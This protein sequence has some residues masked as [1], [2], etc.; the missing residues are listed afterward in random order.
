MKSQSFL[1]RAAGIA[2]IAGL[3]AGC[4]TSQL[5]TL[6]GTTGKA[7]PAGLAIASSGAVRAGGAMRPDRGKSWM[8]PSKASCT[9]NGKLPPC[10]LLYVSNYYDDDVLVF[11]NDKL[12]GTL[13]GFD[14]PDGL[15]HDASGNV[16]IVNNLGQ[17]IVEYAHGGTTQIK[18]LSDPGEFPLGCAVNP[19]TGAVV[20][21]NIFTSGSGQGS[22]AVYHKAAGPP[23]ILTDPDIYYVYFCGFDNEGN[24]YIDGFDTS[25]HFEFAQLPRNGHKF[26]NIALNG[27]IYWPGAI[28]WDGKYV[29]VGDQMYQDQVQ[30]AAYQTTGV[31]G[32]IAG[33]TVFSGAQD[34]VGFDIKDTSIIGP[35]A[36]L[37]IVGL[38]PYPAGGSATAK[39]GH[40][41]H[42]YGATISTQHAPAGAAAP[43][44][45]APEPFAS[46]LFRAPHGTK[47]RGW[48][49]PSVRFRRTVYVADDQEVLIFPQGPRNP[50]PIGKITDGVESAYGLCID[51]YGSLYVANQ[52]SNTVTV[53][54]LGSTEPSQTYSEDLDRP[55]YPAVDS[56]QNLWVTNADNGTVVE[57]KHGTTTVKQVLQ[58]PGT[59]ADGLGFDV[60]GNLYVA[61]RSSGRGTGSIEEFNLHTGKGTLLGMSLNQPQ[62]V[63]VTN[64]GTILTVETGGT[65]QTDRIDVFPPGYQIPTLEVGVKDIPTQLAIDSHETTLFV[66]SLEHDDIYASPYP[67]LNP[68]GSPNVLHEEISV[69]NYGV[70]Q[71]LA[72]SDGQIF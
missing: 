70:V 64:A 63:V 36:N 11:Q 45:L 48:I 35:D 67:L 66:S 53:Y 25:G 38:Y 19:R 33:T 13:T 37:N 28:Q 8:L 5:T 2:A 39:L 65:S 46:P 20:V 57:Y 17:D 24:L 42:P 30:S 47:E 6:G 52:Y 40:F 41:K 32:Q 31:G 16:W 69:G 29:V 61:Y 22:V 1:L 14:G 44:T 10:G 12:V 58:T 59:E 71:G 9:Y 72:L 7:G 4:S 54:P 51:R 15:C 60:Q 23:L 34:V 3:L 21:T 55:L 18:S 56:N 50:A 43:S 62:G 27:T 68:N 49:S 26:K